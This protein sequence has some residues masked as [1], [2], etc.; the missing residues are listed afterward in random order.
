MTVNLTINGWKIAVICIE[1]FATLMVAS[2]A[3]M[4]TGGQPTSNGNPITGKP[5]TVGD[6]GAS[7]FI[8]LLVILLVLAS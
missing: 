4:E 6:A 3:G 5:V 8:S 7:A 1:V 2:K